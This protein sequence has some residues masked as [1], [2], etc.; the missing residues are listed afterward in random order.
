[1]MHHYDMN[2][3]SLRLALMGGVVALALTGCHTSQ[4]TTGNRA[5]LKAESE[6]YEAALQQALTAESFQ[7]KTTVGMG[8]LSLKGTLSMRQ[9]K[10]LLLTVKAPLLGLEIARVEATADSLWLIDK[11]DKVYVSLSIAEMA[12]RIGGD[13]DLE[14]L[15]CLLSGRMYVPGRGAATK[16]DFKRFAWTTEGDNLVGTYTAPDRYT[17]SYTINADNYL[18]A[19]RVTLPDQTTSAEW[20][21]ADHTTSGRYVY[22]A[23]ETLT[24][25]SKTGTL[26]LGAPTVPAPSWTKF[27]PATN[28]KAVTAQELLE[29]LKKMKH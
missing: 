11:Y 24:F 9:K 2:R 27:T 23:K 12:A 4:K 21:Y 18:T 3:R 20:T 19:T 16:S 1:M 22:P 14:A 25:G 17:L 15:Q 8:S 5:V 29:T 6:R 7:S 28:Y 13:V 10:E 26:T